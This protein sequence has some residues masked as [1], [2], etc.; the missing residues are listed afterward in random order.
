MDIDTSLGSAIAIDLSN[1]NAESS[2]LDESQDR[3][4][5]DDSVNTSKKLARKDIENLFVQNS[6]RI[7]TT[8]K[9]AKVKRKS[10]VWKRFSRI[11]VKLLTHGSRRSEPSP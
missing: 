8:A 3:F 10:D 6:D 2:T 9:D 1:D 7:S 5:K 4:N 11:T